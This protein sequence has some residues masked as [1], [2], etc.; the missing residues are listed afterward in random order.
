M[1]LS[2]CN[3]QLYS[4]T[5]RLRTSFGV[6]GSLMHS[7]FFTT[8]A[9]GVAALMALYGLLVL[10]FQLR[11]GMAPGDAV[12]AT[13][14][15]GGG[16][17]DMSGGAGGLG[18]EGDDGA[19][20]RGGGRRGGNGGGGIAPAAGVAEVRPLSSAGSSADLRR[21]GHA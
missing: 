12:A 8:A 16:A 6:A 4:A 10:A 2:S 7:W 15:L 9:A 21:R 19:G 13:G 5:L 18:D 20:G 14:G 3:L 17:G 11:D 1:S